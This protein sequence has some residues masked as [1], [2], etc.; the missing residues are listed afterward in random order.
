MHDLTIEDEDGNP[1]AD[2]YV[3]VAQKDDKESATPGGAFVLF[4]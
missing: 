2:C 1:L 3:R 4:L